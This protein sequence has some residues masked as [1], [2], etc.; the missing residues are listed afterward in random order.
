MDSQK[1][2]AAVV[3]GTVL[4]AFTIGAVTERIRGS[5]LREWEV[6]IGD[7][8]LYDITITGYYSISGVVYPPPFA[9]MNNSLILS[10]IV[11]LPNITIF[12]MVKDFGRLVVSPLKTSSVL[13]NGSEIPIQ[14]Y[15]QINSLVSRCILPIGDWQVLDLYLPD[16]VSPTNDSLGTGSYTGVDLGEVFRI[17]FTRL[18]TQYGSGWFGHVEK[19]SGVPQNMTLWAWNDIEP[20]TYSYNL[21]LVL[22]E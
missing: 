8:F 11:S 2:V 15:E 22:Q 13:G 12:M 6:E 21:T 18:R 17:G 4:V 3:I 7:D 10:T 5:L 1:R 19:T 16:V 14:H 9:D 20:Y